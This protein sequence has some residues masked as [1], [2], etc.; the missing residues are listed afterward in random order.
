[1]HKNQEGIKRMRYM[2]LIVVI[3][4]SDML[5]ASDD[6]C[7]GD[8]IVAAFRQSM[9]KKKSE[10]NLKK[11]LDEATQLF[12]ETECIWNEADTFRK[13]SRSQICLKRNHIAQRAKRIG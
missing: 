8:Q 11:V 2:V 6:T 12:Y 5:V 9:R 4:I 13:V 10:R 1:M 7:F 3:C